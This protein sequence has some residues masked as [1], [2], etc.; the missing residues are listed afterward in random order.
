MTEMELQQAIWHELV[1]FE[2]LRC[3]IRRHYPIK[4]DLSCF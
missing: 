1:L 2:V 3:L 4:F